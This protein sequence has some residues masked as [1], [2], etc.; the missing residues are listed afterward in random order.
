MRSVSHSACVTGAHIASVGV[1][2]AAS[3]LKTPVPPFRGNAPSRNSHNQKN[4]A[5]TE[6]ITRRSAPSRLIAYTS[7]RDGSLNETTDQAV[8][9]RSNPLGHSGYFRW[10]ALHNNTLV[11][12]C[13]DDLHCVDVRGGLPRRITDAPGPTKK[14]VFSPCGSHLAFT[15][16][17]DECEEVYVV[18]VKGGPV[19]RITHVGAERVRVASWSPDGTKLFFVSSAQQHFVDV[20]TLFYVQIVWEG[21]EGDRS[22]VGASEPTRAELGPA[23]DAQFQPGGFG[24]VIGRNTHDPATA[25]WKGYKGGASG[26]VWVDLTGNNTFERLALVDK[27]NST[28][29][30]NI[31]DVVWATKERIV[32]IADDGDGRA[33]LYSF[34]ADGKKARLTKHTARRDFC[35]RHLCADQ[36]VDP[37]SKTITVAYVA[38]GKLFTSVVTFDDENSGVVGSEVPIEWRGPK[39]QLEKF[40]LDEPNE[41]IDDI[42]LHPEGLT[43]VV[44]TRGRVFTMGLWDGPSVELEAPCVSGKQFTSDSYGKSTGDESLLP[45]GSRTLFEIAGNG[46]LGGGGSGVTKGVTAQSQNNNPYAP[47]AR[48]A[49]YLWDATRVLIVRDGKGE[50]D[51]EVHWTD[52]SREARFLNVPPGVLGRPLS[53]TPSTESPLVAI[54][55]H[56]AELLLI[57]CDTGGGDVRSEKNGKNNAEEHDTK[58]NNPPVIR[59]CDT[60]HES[61]GIK[62]VVWSP[63]GCWIA[64]TWYSDCDL[65]LIRVVDVRSGEVH[66]ITHPVL[67]DSCPAWDPEGNYLYFL[68]SRE[69]EP[70][71]DSGKLG[72][73][74]HG[75]LKPHCVSLRPDVKNPLLKRLRPPHDGSD[76]DDDES[77]ADA[78]S[79]SSDS[80]AS[81]CHSDAPPPISIDFNN[82]G[83][84]VLAL[85]MPSGRYANLL[86]LDH[87]NFCLLKFQDKRPGRVGLDVPYYADSASDDGSAGGDGVSLSTGGALLKFDLGNL[88]TS[89]L[90]ESGVRS[91]SLSMDRRCTLLEKIDQGSIEYRALKAGSKFDDEDSDGEEIDFDLCNKRSGLL[92]LESRIQIVVD[93]LKEWTQMFVEAWRVLRDEWVFPGMDPGDTALESRGDD[94][95]NDSNSFKV[96]STQNATPNH[97]LTRWNECLRKYAHL[98]LPRVGAR[99]ELDDVFDEL[100]AELR[101]SHVSI[102]TGDLSSETRRR[103]SVLPGRL[104]CDVRWVNIHDVGNDGSTASDGSSSASGYQS[105]SGGYQITK[106]ITG[107]LWDN[108]SGGCLVKPGV[109]ISVGDVILK[110]NGRRLTKTFGASEALVGA[111]GKEVLLTVLVG[112]RSDGSLDN[113]FDELSL[114]GKKGKVSRDVLVSKNKASK[115]PQASHPKFTPNPASVDCDLRRVPGTVITTRVRAM[116]SELDA[117]YRDLIATRNSRVAELSGNK[118]GYLH[119]PDMER[120]GYSEFWRRFPNESKKHALIVDLRGNGGGHISELILQKLTQ[121]PFALDVPRRGEPV[122]YPSHAMV[123]PVVTIVD[124]DTGSDAELLAISFRQ[125]RGTGNSR[126][127]GVTTWGGLLT[128][129]DGGVTLVDGGYVSFPSQNVVVFGGNGDDK[130]NSSKDSS[131]SSDNKN[132]KIYKPG[133]LVENRGVV[134][135]VSVEVS[136]SDYLKGVDPQLDTAVMEA[137]SLLGV[138]VCTLGQSDI[139]SQNQNVCAADSRRALEALKQTKAKDGSHT[140][141]NKNWPFKTF[142]P[143]PGDE[144]SESSSE[145]ELDS[146]DDA[147]RKPKGASRRR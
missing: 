38:G 128:V 40:K 68:S 130:G 23:H 52:G 100:A 116:Y 146:D 7:S 30:F 82:I 86:G 135:D 43:T 114:K 58:K 112:E 81:A 84:R 33:Q 36:A 80:D 41:F 106:L 47:R 109:N 136:P 137:L 10:P 87:G 98:V 55:N 121:K 94:T 119:V 5:G 49:S 71:Y 78:D 118:V 91:V 13:E 59:L 110:I 17:E 27:D 32:C 95:L 145:S 120:F 67:G 14:P 132:E 134:P 19:V 144:S 39:A 103:H 77:E 126:I 70:A 96:A 90:V 101:S 123:G 57:D 3:R 73:S 63:C 11:F 35:V 48:L 83:C 2:S 99:S 79:A 88:K 64:Y 85:P 66:D 45:P 15:V 34:L 102:S 108:L 138:D 72:L 131:G 6:R 37:D 93:P 29:R 89:V 51:L 20:E 46:F 113:A 62:N 74:F 50:D 117:R 18:H 61:S 4:V 122:T 25:N 105:S 28:K 42:N 75:V 22:I 76:D 31:G 1:P 53:I 12:V 111:G 139:K 44:V 142:A 60:S 65:S 54:V 26:E 115:N 140:Q 21:E 8:Q 69:L 9:M 147:R 107:D 104:G 24:K 92:D 16:E 133:N 56:R 143:Y 97:H 124:Q 125:E 141:K 127:V 129:S